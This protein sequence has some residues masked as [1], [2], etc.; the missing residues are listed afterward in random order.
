MKILFFDGHCSLCNGLV[1]WVM[2]RDKA[3]AIAF[4][5]L[6]GET[7]L[8]Y[9]SAAAISD[10]DTVLYYRDGETLERSTAILALLGD[11]GRPWSAAR[12]LTFIPLP[13][14]DWIYRRIANN[15]YRLFGR[16]DTCRLPLPHEKDRLLS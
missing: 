4:A 12:S 9:L 5:S 11:L 14:R 1:D 16:R 13:L 6:Q 8:R 15:R 10:L 7:A 2:A 3:R